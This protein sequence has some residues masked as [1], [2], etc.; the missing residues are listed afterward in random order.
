MSVSYQVQLVMPLVLL[1][2]MTGNLEL[3]AETS[4]IHV[5]LKKNSFSHISE[6]HDTYNTLPLIRTAIT[7]TI[8]T[9]ISHFL[10]YFTPVFDDKT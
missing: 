4:Q 10:L 9:E 2:Q 1:L 3:F 7:H 5:P 6:H 8:N